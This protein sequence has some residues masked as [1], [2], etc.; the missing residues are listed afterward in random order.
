MTRAALALKQQ[1]EHLSSDGATEPEMSS[2]PTEALARLDRLAT[3][4][5]LASGL[6]HEISNPLVCLQGALEMFD[7][8]LRELRGRVPGADDWDGLADDLDL[9]SASADVITDLVRDFQLFLRPNENAVPAPIDVKD[10]VERAVRMARPRL[11]SIARVE[12]DLEDVPPVL[13]PSNRIT[14]VALNLLLN[15]M[16]A[17]RGRHWSHNLVTVRLMAVGSCA[18]LEVADNGPGLPAGIKSRVFEAGI[19]ERVGRPSTGLGLAISREIVTKMGGAISVTSS[20]GVGT[21]FIVALPR[22]S[23]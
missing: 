1:E 15:A 21:T 5:L 14:Q 18:V 6:A 11:F 19:S 22:E 3:A 8:R 17:L 16:E 20:A 9:A 7:R 2:I 10:A 23:R 13:A 12:V 4:S